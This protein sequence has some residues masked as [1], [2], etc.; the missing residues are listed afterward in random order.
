MPFGAG[1]RVCIGNAFA[2][3]EAV[4]ILAVLLQ[5]NHLENRSATTAEPLMRVTLRPQNPLMMR[6][7]NRKNKSPAV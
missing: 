7:T 5:K 4:A 2:M 3:M 6:V 1:P